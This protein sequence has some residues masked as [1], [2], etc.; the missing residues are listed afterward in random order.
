MSDYHF[1]IPGIAVWLSHILLGLYFIY[2]GYNLISQDNL[3][4]H[5]MILSSMGVLMLSYHAHLWYLESI[6]ESF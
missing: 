5:G 3:K 6:D 1:G 4:V 2:L